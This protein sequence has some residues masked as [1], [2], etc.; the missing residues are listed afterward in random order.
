MP[1][2]EFHR[3]VTLLSNAT[4][5]LDLFPNLVGD[6]EA[7]GRV[8]K[9]EYRRMLRSIHPDVVG[10]LD[11]ADQAVASELMLKL[12]KLYDHAM[13]AIN[14]GAVG[15]IPSVASFD[16]AKASHQTE[17]QLQRYCDMT[18]CYKATSTVN[19]DELATFV[20]IARQPIDNELLRAEFDALTQL[21][22]ANDA[23]FVQFYP[24]PIDSFGAMIAG[25]GLRVNVLR[26][27]DGFYNLEQVRAAY[28]AGVSAL[29][30]GWIWRRILWALKYVHEQ[31]I[32]HGAV[33]PQNIM[34]LPE[35]HG[36][37]LV[38]WCYSVMQSGGSFAPLKAVVRRQ[39]SWYPDDVLHKK[40]PVP[41]LDIALAARSM[42][43]LM[44][45]NPETG[46]T[47][48]TVPAAT[49]RYFAE[50]LDRATDKS[51]DSYDAAP[52]FDELLK[53]LGTPYYP[54]KF[55]PFS[56]QGS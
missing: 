13:A 18:Q 55:R 4:T 50:L 15:M 8:V 35:Q 28:P 23:R 37:V 27:L 51:L 41:A 2:D 26:R 39:R 11:R 21:R 14:A 46:A 1:S 24:E 34:I 52:R 16:S 54:R 9:R 40:P 56:M 7:Q 32:I 17:F 3:A 48:P 38:D 29:D 49:N 5:Y 47:P 31:K 36:V 44:G 33:L 12:G 42:V 19:G 43:Y 25:K 45:G 53:W 20:K 10:S 22:A 30:A 6:H